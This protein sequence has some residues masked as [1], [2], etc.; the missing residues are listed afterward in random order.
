MVNGDAHLI[1]ADGASLTV[2]GGVS[3]ALYVVDEHSLT[4]YGQSSQ[5][6]KL[7]AK[8]DNDH[9]IFANGAVTINGGDIEA[10]SSGRNKCAITSFMSSITV[11]GGKVTAYGGE[12]T[13]IYALQDLAIHGGAVSADGSKGIESDSN[14][15]IDGGTVITTGGN[16]IYT[17]DG[18]ITLGWTAPTDSVTASSYYVDTS[19]GHT[20]K[21]QDGQALMDRATGTVYAGDITDKLDAIKGKTLIPAYGIIIADSMNT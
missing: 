9:A 7:I 20:V 15:T 12:G 17:Y 14:I 13:G 1:L 11:N 5:S 18:D 19:S 8:S 2:N 3:S 16:G 6:G 4:L 21:V 10:T